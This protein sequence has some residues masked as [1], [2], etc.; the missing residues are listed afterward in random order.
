MG[1]FLLAVVFY[2]LVPLTPL[3]FEWKHT[4]DIKLDSLVLTVSIYSFAIGFSSNFRGQ[5]AVCFLLGLL[6]A[7]SYTGNSGESAIP[8]YNTWAFYSLVFVFV[9]H[10]AERY[11]RHFISGESFFFIKFDN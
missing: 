4:G 10:L 8:M 5:L 7:G 9:L 6:L 2:Q 1:N 11:K 3:R